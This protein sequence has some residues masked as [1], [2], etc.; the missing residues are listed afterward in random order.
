MSGFKGKKISRANDSRPSRS[1]AF[2]FS[3]L[4]RLIPLPPT[5]AQ[6]AYAKMESL[7]P[8]LDQAGF[9]QDM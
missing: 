9:Q 3:Y 5:S 6:L 7:L 2:I 4:E 8:L 1:S